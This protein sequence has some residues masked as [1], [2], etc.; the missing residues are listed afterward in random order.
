MTVMVLPRNL[1]PVGWGA[2]NV[3][4][5]TDPYAERFGIKCSGGYDCG[6]L[7]VYHTCPRHYLKGIA[8]YEHLGAASRP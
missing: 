4:D 1:E 5:G 3:D 8:W 6:N 2:F 7:V